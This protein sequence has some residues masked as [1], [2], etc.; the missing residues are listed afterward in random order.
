[1]S[2]EEHDS[3]QTITQDNLSESTPQGRQMTEEPDQ[4]EPVG[5]EQSGWGWGW[6]S[7]AVESARG[8][9]NSVSDNTS[10]FSF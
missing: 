10:N 6:F 5:K 3:G 4:P 9:L 2:E 1:M 8:A 7:D